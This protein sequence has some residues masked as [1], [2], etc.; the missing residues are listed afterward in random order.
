MAQTRFHS[1]SE[2]II[3]IIKDINNGTMNSIDS[4]KLTSDFKNKKQKEEKERKKYFSLMYFAVHLII[5][6]SLM[7]YSNNTSIVDNTVVY[8]LLGL[9][10][11][12]FGFMFW[13]VISK[14]TPRFNKEFDD[15]MT[16]AN[17]YEIHIKNLKTVLL[18]EKEFNNIDNYLAKLKDIGQDVVVADMIAIQSIVMQD[19]FIYGSFAKREEGFK[20]WKVRIFTK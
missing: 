20:E 14:S 7:L 9:I 16:K 18:K 12:P 13:A 17:N 4:I 15:L 10:L 1:G 3:S 19:L 5:F 6:S 11:A 2:V 8:F